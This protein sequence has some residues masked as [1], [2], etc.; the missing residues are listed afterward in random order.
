MSA[1]TRTGYTCGD[2]AFWSEGECELHQK[3][4]SMSKQPCRGFELA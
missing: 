4:V 1:W 2:C 3:E